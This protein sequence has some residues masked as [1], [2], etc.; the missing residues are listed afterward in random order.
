MWKW[1]TGITVPWH[2]S[3]WEISE[4]ARWPADPCNFELQSLIIKGKVQLILIYVADQQNKQRNQSEK[5]WDTFSHHY[6][7]EVI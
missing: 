3:A 6:I 4:F 1:G 7:S 5:V 2:K